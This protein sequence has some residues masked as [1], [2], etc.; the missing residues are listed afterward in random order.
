M[1]RSDDFVRFGVVGC[2]SVA[3]VAHFPALHRNR[4]VR[5]AAVCDR[6]EA[7]ARDAARRWGADAWY[8]EAGEMFSAG[9]LDAV[10]IASPNFLHPEHAGAAADAGLHVLVEKPMAVTRDEAWQIVAACRAA[11]VKLMVG[12]D[13]RFWTH[14]QW[15]KQLIADGVIGDPLSA[16]GSLHEHWRDYQG[17]V[18][19]TDFRLDPAR[20]GGAALPDLGAH[21]IDLLT[22]LV[23]HEVRRVVGVAKRV[24]TDETY[25]TCD[26]LAVLTM[27]HA[28][29]AVSTLT[30]N[31]FSPVVSQSTDI[32][33]TRGTIHTATDATNPFQSVPMAVYTDR[34]YTAVD[35]PEV[36][37]AFRWPVDFWAEDLVSDMVPRRWVPIV[38]PRSP[39]N[40]EA[41]LDHFV[42]CILEDT[43]PLVSGE[44]GAR[45][46]EVMG[47]VHLSMRTGTWVE[48]PL[49][50]NVVPPGYDP[51][52]AE[53]AT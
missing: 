14:N 12:C 28:N 21:A 43:D 8:S 19:L 46:V 15:T 32:F 24:A 30:C 4:S 47:A 26:D 41:M 53:V 40:Y 35:L 5:L 39:S 20:S 27:E 33:G 16:R 38:P 44:D 49:D 10:V 25:S 7:R 36:L 1:M 23:G 29:G 13:R 18:A 50:Q 31:R 22:W 17:K 37:R 2:G 9:G 3:E 6:D 45:A 11:K 52:A 51:A 48:L 34:D 42:S